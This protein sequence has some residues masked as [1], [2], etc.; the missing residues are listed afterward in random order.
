MS[1]QAASDIC[2]LMV[3]SGQ[4]RDEEMWRRLVGSVDHLEIMHFHHPPGGEGEGIIE[5][6][7]ASSDAS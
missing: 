3:H 6:G 2:M 5:V 1:R 7:L 4:E